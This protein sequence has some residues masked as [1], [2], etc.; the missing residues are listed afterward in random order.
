MKHNLRDNEKAEK[1]KLFGDKFGK[2]VQKA[3][4][5]FLHKNSNHV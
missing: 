4:K 3:K 1:F 5:I 2:S